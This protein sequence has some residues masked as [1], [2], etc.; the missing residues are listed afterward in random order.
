LWDLIDYF[1]IP[2]IFDACRDE[3]LPSFG[4][5]AV[6][7]SCIP[8]GAIMLYWTRSLYGDTKAHSAQHQRYE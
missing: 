7:S 1:I 3:N 2:A 5:L 6:K 8:L 4:C